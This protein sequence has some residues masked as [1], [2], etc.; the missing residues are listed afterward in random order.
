VNSRFKKRDVLES[1]LWP[2]K[3]ISD[4]YE[5]YTIELTSGDVVSG[6]VVMEDDRR[7]VLRTAANPDRPVQVPKTQIK[8]Q[9]KSPMSL[10][11]EGLVDE[12]SQKEINALV[13]FLLAGVK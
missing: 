3:V 12:L 10:M 9:E 5:M 4:Q 13:A 6:T 11:P 8:K 7:V 1:M 2:S